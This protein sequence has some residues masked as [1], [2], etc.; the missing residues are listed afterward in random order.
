MH[1]REID[2]TAA[3]V[4]TAGMK[5]VAEADGSVHLAELELIKGL[6]EG[7][8]EVSTEGGLPE[9][10]VD[11]YVRSLVMVALADG[12]ITP[13]EEAVIVNLAMSVGVSREHVDVTVAEVKRE[14]L[15]QFSGVTLFREQ[16]HAVGA[17]L[18][19]SAGE[20]DEV[21]G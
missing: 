17:E 19:L 16:A 15:A 2:D 11:V 8:G 10:L 1:S 3:A 12:V 18:G 14:F 5:A 7:L 6:E 21:V 9:N 13:E 4:I 20:V